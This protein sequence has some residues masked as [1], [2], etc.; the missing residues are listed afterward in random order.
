MDHPPQKLPPGENLRDSAPASGILRKL[1]ERITAM[2]NGNV[3]LKNRLNV[4]DENIEL[5]KAYRKQRLEYAKGN[6]TADMPPAR[7]SAPLAAGKNAGQLL[8]TIYSWAAGSSWKTR[9][10]I[11]AVA[12]SGIFFG[13][14]A[15]KNPSNIDKPE[16]RALPGPAARTD[17]PVIPDKAAPSVVAP[18][19]AVPEKQKE[20]GMLALSAA[21]PVGLARYNNR[22]LSV[23]WMDGRIFELDPAKGLKF[24]QTFPNSLTT[25]LSAGNNCLWSTDAFH[26]RFY[27]H[28][29]GT[30]AILASFPTPG[31]AP[32][33]VYWD[34][35]SLWLA[36]RKTRLVYKYSHIQRDATAPARYQLLEAEPAGLWRTDDLLWVLDQAGKTIRRYRLDKELIPVDTLDISGWLPEKTQ[37][38]G[39]A[40][41]GPEIWI[42]TENP[43][44][45][46]K[47][48]Q[49]QVTW[50][51]MP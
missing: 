6:G 36:D 51:R 25:G 2:K 32:S 30:F 22:W 11:V 44:F 15:S 23:D 49:N 35:S 29:P 24:L 39:L 31:P 16:P 5:E 45:L 33:A 3:E 47:R 42:L 28:D 46:Y 26:H 20:P 40:L 7:I 37:P 13:F 17:P 50:V 43:S 12:L 38:V 19:A 34:G 10:M 8:R 21:H 18:P 1:L 48:G 27:K 9:S 14:L 41:A 4:L